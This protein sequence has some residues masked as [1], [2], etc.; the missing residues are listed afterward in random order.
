[1]EATFTRNGNT[2]VRTHPSIIDSRALEVSPQETVAPATEQTV[3]AMYWGHDEDLQLYIHAAL[4]FARAI[5]MSDVKWTDERITHALGDLDLYFRSAADMEQAFITFCDRVIWAGVYAS[6]MGS[7]DNARWDCL[8]HPKGVPSHPFFKVTAQKLKS[9][10][11]K[12]PFYEVG[13]PILAKAYL[14]YM[15]QP[16]SKIILELNEQ[17]SAMNFSEHM[18]LFYAAING[19]MEG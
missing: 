2:V 6:I 16:S 9:L 10:K 5:G 4:C 14:A 19:P 7:N 1:M 8:M 12:N 15:R 13:L 17:L 11:R 3:P 18:D